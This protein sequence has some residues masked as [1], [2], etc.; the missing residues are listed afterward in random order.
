MSQ[1]KKVDAVT[2]IGIALALALLIGG[3]W[4]LQ[5]KNAV[6]QKAWKA[7]QDRLAAEEA[8]KIPAEA[9]GPGPVVNGGP[10]AKPAPVTA[11]AT[12]AGDPEPADPG[13]TVVKTP[14]L[15]IHF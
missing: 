1:P 9:P 15:E 10:V 7:E 3:Q 11:S 2:V 6:Q 14:R 13:N 5:Q 8:K 4:Y 12:V